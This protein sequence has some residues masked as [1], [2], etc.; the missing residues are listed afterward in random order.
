MVPSIRIEPHNLWCMQGY[1]QKMMMGEQ[2]SGAGENEMKAKSDEAV[3][4]QYF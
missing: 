2:C 3:L 4:I 1:V